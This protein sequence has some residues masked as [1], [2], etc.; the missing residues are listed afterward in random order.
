MKSFDAR[1]LDKSTGEVV[2]VIEALNWWL[3]AALAIEQALERAGADEPPS[4]VYAYRERM[5][6]ALQDAVEA[7]EAL[8]R[9]YGGGTP[10]GGPVRACMG[11]LRGPGGALPGPRSCPEKPSS[12]AS[13]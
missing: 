4:W 13:E 7:L 3:V 8:R 1:T 11:L 5:A 10:H 2:E 9:G 6:H 12:L